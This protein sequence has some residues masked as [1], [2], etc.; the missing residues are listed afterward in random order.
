MRLVKSGIL[1]RHALA[2]EV[3]DARLASFS[4]VKIGDYFHSESSAPSMNTV[5]YLRTRT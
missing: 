3:K 1:V 5:Q 4:I 2:E